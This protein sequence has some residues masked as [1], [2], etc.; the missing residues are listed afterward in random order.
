MLNLILALPIA[1]A[2]AHL[3][4]KGKSIIDTVFML[5]ILIPTMGIAMGLHITMIKYGL[6]DSWVGVVLI[7]LL[8]TLPYSIRILRTAFEDLGVKWEE[9]A[10]SLGASGITLLRTLWLPL[11]LPSI[12]AIIFL[13]FIISMSQYI[14]TVIIGG[15]KVVTLALVYFPYFNSSNPGAIAVLSIIFALLPLLI[16]GLWELII[17]ILFPVKKLKS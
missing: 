17:R 12:R 15:G 9:Q 4:F 7:H 3:D 16:M 6:A 1:K 11:I 5:P 10:R 13:T 8:P 14:L 2:L